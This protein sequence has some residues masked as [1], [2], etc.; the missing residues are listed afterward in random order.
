MA[1][2]GKSSSIHNS[3]YKKI[4]AMLVTARQNAGLTQI[5]LASKLKISQPNISKIE[6][7]ERRIDALEL[8]EWLEITGQQGLF[9]KF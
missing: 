6:R 7:C 8:V 1:Y 2:S 9:K 5:E 4:V 3:R